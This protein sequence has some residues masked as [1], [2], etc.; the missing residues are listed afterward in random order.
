MATSRRIGI[1]SYE[2][3]APA[4]AG[5]PPPTPTAEPEP[6]TRVSLKRAS[7][8]KKPPRQPPRPCL[9]CGRI[10]AARPRGLC[11]A[12]FNDKTIRIR[13]G[14]TGPRGNREVVKR[15]RRRLAPFPTS[16]LP[17][18]DEKVAVLEWRRVE[19]TYSGIPWMLDPLCEYLR[20]NIWE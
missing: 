4:K 7:P 9:E 20:A 16:A 10:L 2:S 18:S 12:C 3:S 1:C 6:S 15:K 8:P 5:I 11:F 14:P 13:Y 19:G 17:G